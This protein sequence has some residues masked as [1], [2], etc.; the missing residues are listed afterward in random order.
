M[1]FFIF[2]FWIVITLRIDFTFRLIRYTLISTQWARKK[3]RKKACVIYNVGTI[4][5]K[6]SFFNGESR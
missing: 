1:I 3:K 2:F 4:V 6:R 5:H